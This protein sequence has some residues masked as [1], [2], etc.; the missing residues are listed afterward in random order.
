VAGARPTV[1]VLE[2]ILATR[3][4]APGQQRAYAI[5]A[6]AHPL[7]RAQEAVFSRALR[8][9]FFESNLPPDKRIWTDKDEFI[10][11]DDLALVASHM[12]PA[13]VSSPQCKASGLGQRFI[14]NPRYRAGLPA[15][16]V[17][18]RLWRLSRSDAAE[19][20]GL[21]ARG[22]EVGEKGW[23]FSGRKRLLRELVE[24]LQTAKNGV[25]IVTGPPGAGKSAVIG[26]LATLSDSDCRREAIEAG[27]VTE[28]EDDLPPVGAIDI[29]V[30]AKGKTLDDCARALAQGLGI[31]GGEAAIDA[32]L[33]LAAIGKIDRNITVVIDALDE[34][35]GRQGN[36]IASQL[37]VPLGR[38]PRIRVLVGSRHSLDGSVVPDERHIRLRAAFGSD[39][40]IDDL[41]DEMDT[42]VD[43]AVYIQRRLRGSEKHH[44]DNPQT[45]KTAAERVAARADGVFL[46]ARIVSRTLQEQDA[47]DGE[48]PAT[49]L[50]AFEQDLSVRFKGGVS[51]VDDLLGALAWAEGKGMTRRVWPLIANAIVG[52]EQAY[53]DV[54]VAWVLGHAGWHIIEAGE[55]GQAVYRLA[56]QALADYYHEKVDETET[57]GRIVDA[58]RNGNQGAG[59]LNCDK[60]LWRHLA[61]HAAKADGLDLDNL[62]RDSGYLAVTD[63]ARLVLA[64]MRVKSAEGHRFADIYNRV[65]DRLIGQSP[66][67][68]MPLIHMTAQMEDPEL[69][70]LLEPPV[71]ARWRCRWARVKASTPHRIMGKHDS[72]VSS[73]A[74]GIIDGEPVIISNSKDGTIRCWGARTNEL[75]GMPIKARTDWVYSV[76]SGSIE[77]API[78]VSGSW[79]E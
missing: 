23:F 75:I 55:D 17:E 64:L 76:V 11:A 52:R 35:A 18:E 49:A 1:S 28:G 65:V 26:R 59:W 31:T 20:F 41:A 50:E 67:D 68:R 21:A 37:I 74:F 48:L 7:E 47:L 8:A 45:I 51:R 4:S 32:D 79:T 78:V 22:I 62:I 57:Q 14:P 77:G 30:H 63:P 70:P 16:N 42:R 71:P 10:T 73:V 54:D 3:L 5:I 43:I 58:S 9:A 66:I 39:A 69:A 36:A 40:I 13:G 34:A 2:G 27:A 56:H 46:Y 72:V 6:S 38:L 44:N 53:D 61:D 12:M 25:R 60:Y 33:L 29:A 19:H 15:E 24:W